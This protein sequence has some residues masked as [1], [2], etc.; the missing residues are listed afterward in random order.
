MKGGSIVKHLKSLAK[1]CTYLVLWLDCDREG[2]NICFE[3]M[4]VVLPHL[5]NSRRKQ[6][7]RAKFSSLTPNDLRKAIREDNLVDPNENESN[8]VDA[9]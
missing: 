9:R 2:E 3:V 5:R 4:D 8:S 1:R 7:Y 6:V